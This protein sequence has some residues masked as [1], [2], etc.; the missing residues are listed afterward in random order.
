MTSKQCKSE[1]F[2]H[3]P[4]GARKKIPEVAKVKLGQE[5]V[6]LEKDI[7]LCWSL[8]TLFSMPDAHPMAFKGGTSLSKI[9]GAINRFSEDVDIT[10]DYRAFGDHLDLFAD[11]VS[12]SAIKKFGK[13]MKGYVLQYANNIVAPYI[14]TQL[15]AMPSPEEYGVNVSDDGEKVW[16]QYP[17]ATESTDSYLC[18]I[19]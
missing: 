14:A 6:L 19:P 12:K 17:S 10:I 4:V 18:S 1:K 2:L 5:A 16:V 15:S 9:Y 8:Q 3:L 7:W 11:G 13:R